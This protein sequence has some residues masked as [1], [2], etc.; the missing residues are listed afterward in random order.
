MQS[1]HSSASVSLSSPARV[2]AAESKSRARMMREQKGRRLRPRMRTG[3]GRESIA[4]VLSRSH[5]MLHFKM[6]S[7]RLALSPFIFF[8]FRASRQNKH[9]SRFD[10]PDPPSTRT[11]N[12]SSP[13][14]PPR[15]RCLQSRLR[16]SGREKSSKQPE[17]RY[18]SG[19]AFALSREGRAVS[20]L[21][22]LAFPFLFLLTTSP[23]PRDSIFLPAILL[24]RGDLSRRSQAL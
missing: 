2:A 23:P 11:N 24:S 14:S 16:A 5:S 21:S 22:L 7:E 20:A 19:T 8:S 1:N 4:T 10:P 15:E 18:G 13:L 9:K 17:E 12:H 6:G 3:G